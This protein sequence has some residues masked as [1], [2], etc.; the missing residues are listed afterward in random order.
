MILLSFI[1]STAS[2]NLKIHPIITKTMTNWLLQAPK[3]W[4]AL[5]LFE[6][7]W[8]WKAWTLK[9]RVLGS[10]LAWKAW[11]PRLARKNSSL[12]RVII[13]Q[14]D[15]WCLRERP[16]SLTHSL[17]SDDENTCGDSQLGWSV[18]LSHERLRE[19]KGQQTYDYLL[20]RFSFC[21]Q[22]I[23]KLVWLGGEQSRTKQCSI[24]KLLDL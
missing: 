3:A 24:Q 6:L 11:E 22:H 18:K 9:A 16:S 1:R 15:R 23:S 7:L 12:D 14:P 4:K 21:S 13:I 10:G 19:I 5:G 8:A 20:V 2:G 17:H